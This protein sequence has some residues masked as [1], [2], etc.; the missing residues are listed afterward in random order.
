MFWSMAPALNLAAM[1]AQEGHVMAMAG[2]GEPNLDP[3]DLDYTR[4]VL[5]PHLQA[6]DRPTLMRLPVWGSGRASLGLSAA[7][8]EP[9]SRSRS[10]PERRTRPER[11]VP[12]P[13]PQWVTT[14][15]AYCASI[16]GFLFPTPKPCLE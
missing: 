9:P 1:L 6:T 10:R 14:I 12:I 11:S 13:F 15:D 3:A 2:C 7:G 5:Q 8:I 4:E 16:V